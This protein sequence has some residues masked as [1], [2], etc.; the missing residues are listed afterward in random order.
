MPGF[1]GL[2]VNVYHSGLEKGRGEKKVIFLNP[3]LWCKNFHL[4]WFQATNMIL[5]KVDLGREPPKA[6]G[7]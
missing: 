1:S 2:V 4:G 5:L 7:S 6:R 3:F